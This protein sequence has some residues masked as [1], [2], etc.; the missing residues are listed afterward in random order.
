MGNGQCFQQL[1][2]GKLNINIQK[3]KGESSLTLYAK[4]NSK[5]IYG[6]NVRTKT[7]QLLEENIEKNF[8]T[9]TLQCFLVCNTKNTSIKEKVD[10]LDS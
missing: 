9:S 10:E 2:L 6:L 7:I 4:I 5:W 3:N 1:V 8:T